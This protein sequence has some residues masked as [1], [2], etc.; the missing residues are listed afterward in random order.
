MITRTNEKI[1][2]I[3]AYT[4]STVKREDGQRFE[5]EDGSEWLVLDEDEVEELTQEEIENSLWAFNPDFIIDHLEN[6]SLDNWERSHCA[7]A[8]SEIQKHHCE[9]INP[10]IRALIGDMDEFVADAVALDGWAHFLARY[11]GR[12]IELEGTDFYAYRIN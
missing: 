3:E 10:I 8:L 12:E 5:M 2:A 4:E 1:R 9:G 11:D 7:E 6:Q